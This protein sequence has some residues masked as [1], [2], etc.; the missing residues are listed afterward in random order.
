VTDA[1][2]GVSTSYSLL[3]VDVTVTL[4][5]ADGVGGVRCPSPDPRAAGRALLV[6]GT[7]IIKFK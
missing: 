3:R 7:S 4:R 1:A 6:V 5:L 2:Y